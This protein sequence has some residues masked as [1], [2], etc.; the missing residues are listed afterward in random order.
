MTLVTP[1]GWTQS[2]GYP[3]GWDPNVDTLTTSDSEALIDAGIAQLEIE[4]GNAMEEFPDEEDPPLQLRMPITAEDQFNT[5]VASAGFQLFPK[6]Q[7]A[8]SSLLAPDCDLKK[9]VFTVAIVVGAAVEIEGIAA[10][11]AAGAVYAEWS[12][13][14]G[15]WVS[16]TPTLARIAGTWF[17]KLTYSAAAG[18]AV[19]AAWLDKHTCIHGLS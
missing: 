12:V 5:T 4:W 9:I 14:L 17:T 10:T 11:A 8:T 16:K 7:P 19:G 15:V 2:S 18:V 1:D 13:A 6:V 3:S